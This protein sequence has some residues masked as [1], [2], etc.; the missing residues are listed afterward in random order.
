[1]LAFLDEDHFL[2]HVFFVEPSRLGDEEDCTNPHL[3]CGTSAKAASSR[4]HPNAVIRP[5]EDLPRG[6]HGQGTVAVLGG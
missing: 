3:A 4:L 5:S 1:M 6:I 2:S